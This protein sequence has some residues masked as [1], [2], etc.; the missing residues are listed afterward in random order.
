[1]QK[2]GYSLDLGRAIA[3]NGET[4]TGFIF[5]EWASGWELV[6]LDDVSTITKCSWNAEVYL[7]TDKGMPTGTP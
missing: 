5:S 7:E 2:L 4:G 3:D 6:L 1:M